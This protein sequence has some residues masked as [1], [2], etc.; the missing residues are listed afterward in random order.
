MNHSPEFLAHYPKGYG[1]YDK[2]PDYGRCCEAVFGADTW[3]H[4]KQCGRKNGFGPDGAYCK[5]HDPVAVKAK[6]EAKNAKWEADWAAK[7]RDEAFIREAKQAVI[8][9]A[10][11]HNDPSALCREILDRRGGKA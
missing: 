3:S 2:T 9:I 4:A 5:Q 6:R 8:D 10:A 11:G 7:Q 1:R